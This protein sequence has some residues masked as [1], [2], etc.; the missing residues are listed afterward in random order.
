MGRVS[1]KRIISRRLGKCYRWHEAAFCP[2]CR[3]AYSSP[4]EPVGSPC[5]K[6]G[7]TLEGPPFQNGRTAAPAHTEEKGEGR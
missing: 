2:K 4:Q 6:C 5:P 7:T 1:R 3:F